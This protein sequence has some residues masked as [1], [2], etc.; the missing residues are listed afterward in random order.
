MDD[1]KEMLMKLLAAR[2]PKVEIEVE[3]EPFEKEENE[4]K[5]DLAPKGKP[6]STEEEDMEMPPKGEMVEHEDEEQDMDLI[7]EMLGGMD[8]SQLGREPKGLRE[9]AIFEA[10]KRKKQT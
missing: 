3:V 1:K 2:K 5:T 4:G 10:L 6:M 8:E 7:T 9:R